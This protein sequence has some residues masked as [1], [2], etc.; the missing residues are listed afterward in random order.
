MNRL[1]QVDLDGR[2]QVSPALFLIISIALLTHI[3]NLERLV[4][5]GK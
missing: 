3:L 4:K 2:R 5:A 1:L